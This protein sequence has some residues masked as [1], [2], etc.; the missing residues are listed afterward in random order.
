MATTKNFII[1]ALSTTAVALALTATPANAE[2]ILSGGSDGWSF[3]FDGFI[4]VFAIDSSGGKF[5]TG[6]ASAA[7]RQT[8]QFV[9][10]VGNKFS[11]GDGLMPEAFGFNAHSPDINGNKVN[12]RLSLE[13]G[14]GNGAFN[15]TS[16]TN[17]S[18]LEVREAYASIGGAWGEFQA[19][20]SLGIF[21]SQAIANDITLFGV[22]GGAGAGANAGTTTLGRIGYG[23]QYA[24][25]QP[26]IRYTTPAWNGIKLVVGVFNPNA[27]AYDSTVSSSTTA[28]LTRTPKIEGGASW[29]GKVFDATVS[30]WANGVWQEATTT[31]ASTT[32]NGITY[33]YGNGKTISTSGGEL[34]TKIA[35]GPVDVVLSGYGGS[36]LAVNGFQTGASATDA[37]GSAEG[38]YG[39]YVQ[40]VYHFGQGTSIGGSYGGNFANDTSIQQAAARA[41]TSGTLTQESMW[42]LQVWHEINKNFRVLA[43]FNNSAAYW[44]DTASQRQNTGALG[45]V[46]TF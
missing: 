17:S 38:T 15:A 33:A 25:W 42:V 1:G 27:I 35:Y 2:I 7:N 9:S 29:A 5:G 40:A 10:S 43:E 39:G 36:A 12:A 20:K 23:Y 3:G 19:G 28:S 46:A 6:Y 31:A 26:N 14:L 37:S 21:G 30:V 4:N 24:G 22:G 8:S 41:G 16:S 44:N 45:I 11:V 18:V 13:P 34:G 32:F